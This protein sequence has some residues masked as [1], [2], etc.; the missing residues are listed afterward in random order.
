MK[1]LE[2]KI[3]KKVYGWEIKKTGFSLFTKTILFFVFGLLSV[4]FTQI[5]IEVFFET[6]SDNVFEILQEDW[7]VITK[8][9]V[10]VVFSLYQE[11]PK[12]LVFVIFIS[13]LISL[14]V[15]LTFVKNFGIM[16]YK[17]I[18]LLRYWKKGQDRMTT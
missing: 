10:D 13:S 7:Q 9:G 6:G 15:L 17:V 5:L 11:I 16:R 14:I 4:F 12:S 3:I 8:H 1:K 2:D 18:A